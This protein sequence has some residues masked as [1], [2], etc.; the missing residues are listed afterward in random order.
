MIAALLAATVAAVVVSPSPSSAPAVVWQGVGLGETVSAVVARMGAPDTRRKAIM[1]TYLLEY[2]ALG[3]EA[4]LSLT[5]GGGLITGI[6]LIAADPASLH[7]PVTDP[8]GVALGDSADRLSEL[9]GQPQRFDD[10]G[11][12]E[13]TSY[14]GKQ[15]DARWAYGLR[16][17]VIYSIGVISAYRV[18]RANGAAVSVPTPRPSGA[19]T[20]PPPDASAFD[21]AVKVTAEDVDA[22]PQFEFTYVRRIACGANDRWSPLGE[23]IL[24]AHRR[25]ISRVDA[26][27]PS[28]GE[29]RS[30]YFDITDVFGRGDR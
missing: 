7:T 18:V 19:P 22:D 29:R 27:C 28:T 1:G 30:F 6:R 3:G 23:T 12:G 25:N 2:K 16:D 10:E 8:F 20:P 4:T 13:F 24:N 21:R 17:G 15:S 5:D 9:R 26:V 11:G 14:Y